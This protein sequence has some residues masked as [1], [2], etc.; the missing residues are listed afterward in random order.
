[1]KTLTISIAA[2]NQERYLDRCISSLIIPSIDDLEIFVVND[3]SKDNT[4][5]IAHRWASKYP[6]SI[7]AIDKEN[8]HTGSCHNR[9]LKEATAKYYRILDA[10][11]YYD[12]AALE[13]F[14]QRLKSTDADMLIT[15][16]VICRKKSEER[17]FPGEEIR[18]REL[19]IADVD[20]TRNNLPSCFGMHGTT[21]KLSLIRGGKFA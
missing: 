16:H 13:T 18:N 3:G 8:G 12:T 11:D 15:T 7:F 10:D 2:Y 5:E 14:V 9:T 4:S 19:K 17:I 6:S 21:Y 20:F 1:M